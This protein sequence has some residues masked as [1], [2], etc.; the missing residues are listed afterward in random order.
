[1]LNEL[2][3]LASVSVAGLMVYLAWDAYQENKQDPD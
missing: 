3:A 2:I 1:M